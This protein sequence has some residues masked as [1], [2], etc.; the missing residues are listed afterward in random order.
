MYDS[1]HLNKPNGKQVRVIIELTMNPEATLGETIQ[2][3]RESANQI[4]DRIAWSGPNANVTAMGIGRQAS[5]QKALYT[6][7]SGRESTGVYISGRMV[8][9]A[10]H[11]AR[12]AHWTKAERHRLGDALLPA[13]IDQGIAP[14]D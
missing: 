3:V 7:E 2:A 1:E 11:A 10:A 5:T 8:P 9:F 6:V 12:T 4:A 13:L 14:I